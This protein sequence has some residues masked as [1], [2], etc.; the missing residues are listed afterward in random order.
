VLQQHG[1]STILIGKAHFQ[2]LASTA[3]SPSLEYPPKFQELDF[4]RQ[5]RGPWYGFQ[6]VEVARG[7]A[8]EPWVGQHYALWME[9][10]GFTNWRDYFEA[11]PSDP[12][13]PPRQHRWELPEELHYTS[14][15]GERMIAHLEQAA[16]QNKPFFMFASFHD[17]HP[18]YLVP[19]PWASMYRPEEMQPGRLAE[20]ELALLPPHFQKTQE[21]RP[22]FSMYRETFGA[23]GFHSHLIDDES[24]RRDIAIYYGII[25]FMDH[26][27]GRILDALDRLGLT[28][29]TLVVFASDHGHFLGQHGLIAKGPFH[30]EDLLRVP[31]LLRYPGRV[32]KGRRTSALQSHVDFAPTFLSAAGIETPGWMQG[33]DQLGC[34]CGG[35][36]KARD[37]VIVE[38]RFE[39]TLVHLRT[40]VDERYKITVYR[41]RDWGEL[42]DLE[43]DPREE[44]NLWDNPACATLKCELLRRF[45][46]AELKREPTRMKRVAHA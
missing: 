34:W 21:P 33:V 4:W 2:P 5:F 40:Y 31:M 12:E 11:W 1:Y 23:H 27:I 20:G 16:A 24:L 29:N 46:N 8:D 41:D 37:H 36:E 42:F 32:A 3:D 30:F 26:W 35:S 18:P 9:E 38:D 39:L 19:E 7:H 45:I 10:K 44:R 13:S 43:Q 6:E 25:S 14:W 15:T 17:P 28:E 22:D